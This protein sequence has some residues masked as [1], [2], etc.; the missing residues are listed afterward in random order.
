MICI[1]TSGNSKNIINAVQA[2]KQKNITSIGFLGKDGG[3][4][5]NICDYNIIVPSNTT[6]RIQE[7]HIFLGHFLCGFVERD[8]NLVN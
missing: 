7:A 6:A 8:L 1:S 5:K 3:N 2:A 4:L